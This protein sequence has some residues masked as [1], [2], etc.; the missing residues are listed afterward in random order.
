MR[1]RNGSR[2]GSHGERKNV[3]WW[4]GLSR[5]VVR[6]E[7]CEDGVT[8][9]R[10]GERSEWYGESIPVTWSNHQLLLNLVFLKKQFI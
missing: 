9:Q 8:L 6:A 2:S 5:R 10:E 3:D 7:E 1:R 4:L